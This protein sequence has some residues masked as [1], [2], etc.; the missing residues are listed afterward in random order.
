MSSIWRKATMLAVCLA[1]LPAQAQDRPQPD[2]SDPAVIQRELERQEPQPQTRQGHIE[3]RAP[4]QG[5]AMAQSEELVASAIRIKGAERLPHAA[6]SSAI[7]PYL[8]RPLEQAELVRLATDVAG[9]ARERGYGLATAWVPAQDLVGGIL[10]VE[11]DEGRIDAVRATGPGARLV[12]QRMGEVIGQGPVRTQEL[13]RQLLIIGDMAG[14]WVG[15]ARLLREGGRNVLALSTRYQRTHGLVRLDNWGTS[16][17]GPVRAWA[18]VNFNGLGV[19]GDSLTIG[20]ALTP[21]QPEEFQFIEAR[22]RVPLGAGGTMFGVGGYIGHTSTD[23]GRSAGGYEGESKQVDV[24]LAH[25]LARARDASLWLTGRLELRDSSLDQG[26]LRVR[27]DRIAS[28]SASFYGFGRA[29]GGRI[30]ARV[31]L[32]Q[33]LDAF[34][35]TGRDDP[36]ASRLDAGGVFTKL[37]SWGEYLRSLGSGFSLELAVRSQISDGPLLASEEMGLGGPQFL[38]AFDYRELSGDEGAAGS[39]ELRFDLKEVA[40]QIDRIQFYT[41]VDGGRVSNH[42]ARAYA[43]DIASA[44]GGARLRLRNGW[45]ANAELGVPLTDGGRDWDPKPRFSFAITARF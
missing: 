20:A 27:D 3:F 28:A 24:E 33:G 25:P 29:A 40:P 41:F 5:G 37:E 19:R 44:G 26:S 4:Q 23:D 12:E 11:I 45:E 36:L 42:G 15:E 34:G 14:L 9:A 18:E 30:R 17:V 6:F 22:Y 8:G 10:T 31:S 21:L 7:E 39:A 13:E 38:R 2:R 35:A 43:G 32:I 16:A 1:A